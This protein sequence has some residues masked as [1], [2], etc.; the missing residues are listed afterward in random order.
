MVHES[1]AS[2][3]V[4]RRALKGL[5]KMEG[6]YKQKEGGARRKGKI[7]WAGHPPLGEGNRKSLHHVDYLVS[8]LTISDWLL[9][10]S[11]FWKGLK[12]GLCCAFLGVGGEE[13]YS[14][15][16]FNKKKTKLILPKSDFSIFSLP[17][18]QAAKFSTLQLGEDALDDK[19]NICFQNIKCYCDWNKYLLQTRNNVQWLITIA[20]APT[21]LTWHF[22]FSSLLSLFCY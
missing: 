15:I 1:T 5:Y 8:V 9:Q 11:F 22:T 18:C 16:L 20:W 19:K 12:L 21:V 7:V 13:N 14:F 4:N 2:H 3:L 17:P 10:R 6:L